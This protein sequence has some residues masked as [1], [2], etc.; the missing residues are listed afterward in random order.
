M[1][2]GKINKRKKQIKTKQPQRLKKHPPQK[3]QNQFIT[4]EIAGQKY[5]L[6]F[7]M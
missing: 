1:S 2:V 6:K 4:Y 3:P 7:I 5:S